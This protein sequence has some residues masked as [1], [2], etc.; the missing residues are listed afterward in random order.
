MALRVRRLANPGAGRGERL[1]AAGRDDRPR[2]VVLS[3][4]H[5]PRAGLAQP[6]LLRRRGAPLD[7]RPLLAFAASLHVAADRRS[8]HVRRDAAPR[9]AAERS[10]GGGV[11]GVRVP[12]GP[13][14][15][16]EG[17]V[18]LRR[19]DAA[20]GGRAVRV[21]LLLGDARR[22]GAAVRRHAAAQSGRE[23]GAEGG[24]NGR[25]RGRDAVV[26]RAGDAAG[27][28]AVAAAAAA[29]AVAAAAAP[30]RRRVAG[31]SRRRDD[32][33]G[34]NGDGRNRGVGKE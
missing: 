18:V 10:R 7:Q 22:T 9:P 34:A 13:G 30:G 8:E 1:P 15:A 12:R 6:A 32:V 24:R 33:H 21:Q 3:P 4:P 16:G 26:Q 25:G 14:A 5:A 11:A 31:Q 19:D 17:G 20:G 2:P 27:E 29:A 23:R 28:S